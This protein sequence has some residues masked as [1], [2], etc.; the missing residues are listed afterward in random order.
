MNQQERGFLLLTS[1]LGNPQR[2]PVGPATVRKLARRISALPQGS[3]DTSVSPEHLTAMGFER[4]MAERIVSLLDDELLLDSYLKRGTDAGCV[5]V[6]RPNPQYPPV[7]LRKLGQDAPGCLWTKGDRSLFMGPMFA[8]VGSRVL[9]ED[10][11]RFAEEAGCQAAKQGYTLVS[12]NA[13]G[14]DSVAQ[15]AC[16]AAGGKV[17]SV[18][19]DELQNH[20]ETENVLYISENDFDAPFLPQRAISRNRVIHALGAVT[21]AAQCTLGKGGTWD[22]SVKNLR[23][24][25][26]TL[27]VFD[28]CSPGARE[29][30]QMGA[31]SVS[32][33][34]L[35]NLGQLANCQ[36][37]LFD[38]A[39]NNLSL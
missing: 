1:F 28:D 13:P 38:L 32:F 34:D 16:L 20:P 27:C 37:S 15:K 19:A 23:Y 31:L 10:N 26:S 17:I 24:G 39:E 14:A 9:R 4:K 25:W 5:P 2:R 3:E 8:V 35:E 11:A 22:G 12:G 33:Q 18:V 6:S 21:L 7:L 30:A 29:L 36:K